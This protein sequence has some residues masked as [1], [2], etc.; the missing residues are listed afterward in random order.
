MSSEDFNRPG[1]PVLQN[2]VYR[3]KFGPNVAPGGMYLTAGRP[4]SQA[5]AAPLRPQ[6]G[7]T[8]T[9]RTLLPTSV[10]V[11]Y[12]P[13]HF[14]SMSPTMRSLDHTSSGRIRNV[15]YH[16]ERPLP[17]RQL[18]LVKDRPMHSTSTSSNALP[19]R[20]SRLLRDQSSSTGP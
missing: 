8:Q 13:A 10:S 15:V 3:I 19:K 11:S 9:V 12:L 2:G 5:S 1:P 4:G 20:T 16:T 14:S 17:V 18:L 6:P 7:K